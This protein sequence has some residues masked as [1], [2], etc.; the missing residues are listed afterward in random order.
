M[1]EKYRCAEKASESLVGLTRLFL[2]QS[3]SI[4]TRGDDSY[5]KCED[6]TE[7]LQGTQQN[8]GNML[9][10]KVNNFLVTDPK[11]MDI[12]NLPDKELEIDLLRK[13]KELQENTERQ[14]NKIKKK[15]TN[16][17]RSLTRR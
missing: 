9:Q 14:F 3:H 1:E 7:G 8:Q 17:T 4:K 12:C 15:Y 11:D 16:K 6:S 2:S 13:L 5:F 10:S